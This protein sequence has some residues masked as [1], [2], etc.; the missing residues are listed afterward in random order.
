MRPDALDERVGAIHAELLE[1]ALVLARRADEG[2][3]HSA[4]AQLFELVVTLEPDHEEARK[5]LGQRKRRG[6]WQQRSKKVEPDR[7]SDDFVQRIA[8]ARMEAADRFEDALDDAFAPYFV[9]RSSH[10]DDAE[11]EDGLDDVFLPDEEER[12]VETYLPPAHAHR[13]RV[14]L[15]P[16]V[17]LDPDDGPRRERT[18]WSYD[19]EARA[20]V[21]REVLET[22]R[23]VLEARAALATIRAGLP[24]TRDCDVDDDSAA[25]GFV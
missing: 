4:A 15:A 1:E 18:W 11:F 12:D 5:A 24:T 23:H 13:L 7:A 6:E 10:D 2:E 8:A 9:E 22:R 17:L 21:M 20:W 14:A 16:V 19:D 3:L 25:T